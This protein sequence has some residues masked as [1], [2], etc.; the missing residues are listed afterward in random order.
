MIV[1]IYHEHEHGNG[2]VYVVAFGCFVRLLKYN[3]STRVG[4]TERGSS[5]VKIFNSSSN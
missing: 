1:I 3:H 2:K 4:K 5:V